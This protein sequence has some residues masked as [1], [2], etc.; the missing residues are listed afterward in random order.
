MSEPG[1]PEGRPARSPPRSTRHQLVG[2]FRH[3]AWPGP[4]WSPASSLR[5]SGHGGGRH[6]GHPL[7]GQI[8]GTDRVPVHGGV[9]RPLAAPHRRHA[10]LRLRELQAARARRRHATSAGSRVELLAGMVPGGADQHDPGRQLHRRAVPR[11]ARANW[12]T[13]SAASGTPVAIGVLVITLVG[14]VGLFIPCYLGIRLGARLRHHPRHRLHGADHPAGRSCRSSSPARFHWSNISGFHYRR[15]E[16]C[17]APSSSWAGSSSSRG[18]ASPW[19]R[20]PATSPNAGTR[21]GTPRSP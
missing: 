18:T 19:R 1:H 5:R 16:D 2:R 6:P 4:S 9:G 17:R 13:R 8:I 14:L 20:P 7:G 21:P 10:V 3:R 11:A 12:W 15:S